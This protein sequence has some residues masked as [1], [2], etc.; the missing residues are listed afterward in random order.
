MTKLL[1]NSFFELMDSHKITIAVADSG[2]RDTRP[3]DAADDIL[4][5]LNPYIR[6]T[7]KGKGGLSLRGVAF[8]TVLAILTV[9]AVLESTLPC[10]C[11]SY[12]KAHS[13]N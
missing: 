9:L 13:R 10:V 8:M 12:K 5:Y 6:I 3:V 1:E 4:Q 7:E 11:L 2:L